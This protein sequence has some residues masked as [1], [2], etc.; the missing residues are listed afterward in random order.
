MILLPIGTSSLVIVGRDTTSLHRLSA[1]AAGSRM[2]KWVTARYAVA[3]RRSPLGFTTSTVSERGFHAL[4]AEKSG[5]RT[6][7]LLSWK[8]SATVRSSTRSMLLFSPYLV[9]HRRQVR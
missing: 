1:E 5:T 9:R 3:S 7:P 8:R 6:R 4:G 2:L